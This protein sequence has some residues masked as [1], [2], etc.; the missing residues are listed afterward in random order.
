M[1]DKQEGGLH[2]GHRERLRKRFYE[3]GADG[4]ADHEL[5][6]L[7]LTYCIARKDVNPIA[8][9]LLK[10][11]KTFSGVLDASRE[12]LCEVEGV[13]EYAAGFI[14]LFVHSFSRYGLARLNKERPAFKNPEQSC[15]YARQLYYGDRYEI[16]YM[17]CLDVKTRLL[18][19]VEVARG[20]IDQAHFYPRKI[21]ESAL[22]AKAHSVIFVHN[23]PSGNPTPS[24]DDVHITRLLKEAL[25]KV[26]IKL[27]DHIIVGGNET[28]SFARSGNMKGSLLTLQKEIAAE[29]DFYE[30]RG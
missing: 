29:S 30:K 19:V 18:Q 22:H 14:T 8:H 23:H 17:L 20:T 5:L 4:F 9:R 26:E 28:Y 21:I 16:G 10:K 12:E 25:E 27:L 7:M 3:N 11:F 2:Q 1:K 15:E 13:G 24:G 6:E